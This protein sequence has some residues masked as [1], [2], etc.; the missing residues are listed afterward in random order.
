M[1][2]FFYTGYSESLEEDPVVAIEI[3]EKATQHNHHAVIFMMAECLLDYDGTEQ[4]IMRVFI[5]MKDGQNTN[6]MCEHGFLYSSAFKGFFISLLW[7][8]S[9]VWII[10]RK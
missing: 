7:E 1:G 9:I 10:V 5:G 8:V 2:T 6:T 4:S 3:S